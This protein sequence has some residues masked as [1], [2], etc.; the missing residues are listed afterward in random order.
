MLS[1]GARLHVVIANVTRP[2]RSVNIRTVVHYVAADHVAGAHRA[3]DRRRDV[4]VILVELLAPTRT[5]LP[6]STAWRA[7][8]VTRAPRVRCT[9]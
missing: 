9:T 4:G 6:G 7:N 5:Q 1:D 2:H 3:G 8:D